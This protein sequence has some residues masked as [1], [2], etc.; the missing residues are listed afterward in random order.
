MLGPIAT[1][2]TLFRLAEPPRAERILVIRLGALG[3]V[4]RTRYAF[5]GVRALY[6][7]A[8]IDWLVEDRAAAGLVDLPGLDERVELRRRKL[9]ARHPRAAL[10]T[11]RELSRE[12]RARSYDLSIDFHG[13]LRSGL[14]AWA[15]GIPQRVGYDAPIAKEMSHWFLTLRA[16]VPASHMS[17]FERNRALVRY[18]GGDVPLHPKVLAPSAREP[19]FGADLPERFALLHPGTSP[20]TTYKRWE[21]ERFG[22]VARGLAAQRGLTSLVAYGPV[23]GEREAARAVVAAAGG[24]AALAPPTE[25]LQEFL[26]LLARARLFV[27][28]DSGPMHLAGLAGTPVVAIFGPTDPVENAPFS[29]VPSQIVRSDVGCN[30]CREGCPARACMRAVQPEAVLAAAF[31]L[32]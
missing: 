6:P 1:D 10:A 27:G 14:L 24:A 23:A 9:R 26:A 11:L 7:D 18:L 8:K 12:L 29:G 20:K 4:V 28:C 2:A 22:A 3:D 30:P 15:A 21:A 19:A 25:S 32:L 31:A 13:V 17:R 16:P 5:A